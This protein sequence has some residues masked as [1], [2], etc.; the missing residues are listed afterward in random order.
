MEPL[1]KLQVSHVVADIDT[2]QSMVR[3]ITLPN[4]NTDQA[5]VGRGSVSPALDST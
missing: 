5:C 1:S 4:S 2:L 3:G